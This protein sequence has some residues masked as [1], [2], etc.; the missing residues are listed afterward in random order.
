M[1][2]F[3]FLL[4]FLSEAASGWIEVAPGDDV[5]LPCRAGNPNINVVKWTRTDLK[6]DIVL[7]YKD[8]HLEN[9]SQHPSYKDRV[10]LVDRDL[11]DGD[12]S[13]T[14]KKVTI[15]D[16]GT[17]EC[18]VKTGDT[19]SDRPIRTIILK[20]TDLKE[21]T[22]DPGDDV[23]LPCRADFYINVVKWTR[24]DLEPDT[25]LLYRDGHLETDKQNP[26]FKDRV[27]LVNR[28]QKDPEVSLILK[29]VN[30]NDAGTYECRVITGD[31]D[32]IRILTIIHLQVTGEV[33]SLWV[34][35]YR[36]QVR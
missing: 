14:L 5:I 8:G 24:P 30:I 29:N 3:L 36:L 2:P 22:V 7:L 13:L 25:V 32:H 35:F 21:V 1:A 4:L 26:S 19:D 33:V 17:Y 15:N 11:E 20:V 9:S 18:R 23:L 12:M 28:K 34:V 6:T 27:N 10:D 31:T 16:T